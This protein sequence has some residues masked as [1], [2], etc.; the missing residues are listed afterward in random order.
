[1]RSVFMSLQICSTIEFSCVKN[2]IPKSQ[3]KWM[4]W[5]KHCFV[6]YFA[7]FWF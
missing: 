4:P 5:D 3:Q 2:V 1:M 6:F 7:P